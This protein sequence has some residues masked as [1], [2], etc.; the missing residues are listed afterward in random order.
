MKYPQLVPMPSAVQDWLDEQLE[1]RGIDAVVYTRYI[2]SLLQRD[3][4]DLP[5]NTL[6]L[7][8]GKGKKQARVGHKPTSQQ[9]C[10]FGGLNGVKIH[11]IGEK[12]LE[13]TSALLKGMFCGS[14]E[15]GR[16]GRK[17]ARKEDVWDCE[18]LKRSAA[19]ECLMS[20]SDQKF[21][22]EKLVDELC[23]KLKEIQSE[24]PIHV[25]KFREG[26]GD[27]L[28]L[29]TPII[30][31]WGTWIVA[32]VYYVV[33]FEIVVEILNEFDS[34]E[35]QDKSNIH[36][37][38]SC[39]SQIDDRTDDTHSPQDQVKKYY[40]AFPPLSSK[41]SS[42]N[43]ITLFREPS[44][45]WNRNKNLATCFG[46]NQTT[47][48]C[49]RVGTLLDLSKE[50]LREGSG[51][52]RLRG[53]GAKEDSYGFAWNMAGEREVSYTDLS[54]GEESG[55]ELLRVFK[56]NKQNA[57]ES[58]GWDAATAACRRLYERQTDDEDSLTT[59][60]CDD[61]SKDCLGQDLDESTTFEQ[62]VEDSNL[63]Q[64]IAKFDHSIEALWSPEDT[65]AS[66]T[67][68]PTE[69]T[70]ESEPDVPVD[71]N[72]LL[73]S[74][75]EENYSV[76]LYNLNNNKQNL[77]FSGNNSFIQ[78]GTN[79]INSIWS[80]KPSQDN[81]IEHG[82]FDQDKSLEGFSADSAQAISKSKVVGSKLH[83][84]FKPNHCTKRKDGPV[85]FQ[86]LDG[87]DV[88]KFFNS[89][90]AEETS[91]TTWNKFENFPFF[92]LPWGVNYT[93]TELALQK[94]SDVG[95]DTSF[96]NI[97]ISG[98]GHISKPVHQA[99]IGMIGSYNALNHNK[100]DS[101]FTEVIPKQVAQQVSE[102]FPSEEDQ[103]VPSLEDD[104]V[105][106]EG[107]KDEEDLLT[108]S[109]THF[110]PI[111]QES[112]DSHVGNGGHYADGT[113]FAIPNNLDV[114]AFKR[115]ESGALYIQTEM[116]D[117]LPNKY[118]EYKEKEPYFVIRHKSI[119][120]AGEPKNALEFIPKFQVCQNEKY[121]QTEETEATLP[122]EVFMSDDE[123]DTKRSRQ[124][125]P[126][127]F[128]FPGDELFAAKSIGEQQS[129]CCEESL[130]PK[131]TC[132]ALCSLHCSNLGKVEGAGPAWKVCCRCGNNNNLL[133][134][135]N[136]WLQTVKNLDV[137][138][139]W[140]PGIEKSAG[141]PMQSWYDIWR[142]RPES[143]GKLCDSCAYSHCVDPIGK[144]LQ[145]CQLREELSQDGEQLLS[146][147]SYL[148]HLYLG[149][150]EGTF[151]VGTTQLADVS[152]PGQSQSPHNL[153]L[154]AEDSSRCCQGALSARGREVR[155][156]ERVQSKFAADTS[157]SSVQLSVTVAGKWKTN[158]RPFIGKATLKDRKRRHSASTR[159]GGP[160][161]SH[162]IP[163][164]VWAPG[165]ACLKGIACCPHHGGGPFTL[166]PVTL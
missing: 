48:D 166:R 157:P 77:S 114:V 6:S 83:P 60:F 123:V 142:A 78:C 90:F 82:D 58:R 43:D 42:N 104:I 92:S 121:C 38:L 109:R 7:S 64:L 148:Q 35:A 32:A 55:G 113:T 34:E 117:D 20:A 129:E 8:P 86:N 133:A 76:E 116:A 13:L 158:E 54:S 79:L 16:R 160:P 135:R 106:S 50:N 127:E 112:Q 22:I 26:A 132:C 3:S 144:S 164:R 14:Q 51:K 137:A 65:P 162:A 89:A 37:E 136:G 145:H 4:A 107:E 97:L 91:K 75:S 151:P 102:S 73:S 10:A 71:F 156:D 128:F 25:Q 62:G 118:M 150:D 165:G 67:E 39:T 17:R 9:R 141:V 18:R 46:K 40:E 80:D 153:L 36:L 87:V 98:Y 19:V 84:D 96:G 130:P 5:D 81:P 66:L 63:A 24:A 30:T 155:E 140:S 12:H 33:N 72:S 52:M 2:L 88:G 134:W 85:I 108:S 11:R 27:V 68:E 139:V 125:D 149:A 163:C 147:L 53:L 120:C 122:E 143:V 124:D 95:T 21:G 103:H 29:P 138:G 45:A 15:I 49:G 23:D 154:Y 110:R 101:S 1:A 41:V 57:E 161:S 61:S 44:A 99:A 126:E 105:K 31:K 70:V 47:T 74:P 93:L 115:S 146:D 111:R 56:Y 159:A 152:S 69:M 94:W 28:L 59:G 131:L 119:E 100:E